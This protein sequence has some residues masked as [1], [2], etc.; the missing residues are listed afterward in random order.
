[1][2]FLGDVLSSVMPSSSVSG[3]GDTTGTGGNASVM[4]GMSSGGGTPSYDP[5]TV[6][7]GPDGRYYALD[8]SGNPF[9][10]SSSGMSGQ[11]GDNTQLQEGANAGRTSSML[12]QIMANQNKDSDFSLKDLGTAFKEAAPGIGIVAGAGALGGAFGSLGGLAGAGETGAGWTSGYDLAGGGSLSGMASGAAGAVGAG[13]GMPGEAGF[14]SGLQSADT[15]R[16]LSSGLGSGSGG[17]M[18]GLSSLT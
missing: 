15:A 1:M 10:I 12:S 14:L 9:M 17:F 2:S 13:A 16:L 4:S 3:P 11:F 6:A 7:K 5:S 18:S 8:S